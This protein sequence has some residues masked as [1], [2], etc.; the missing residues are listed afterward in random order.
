MY[1]QFGAG[2]QRLTKGLF[3]WFV[4]FGTNVM[5]KQSISGRLRTAVHVL[6]VQIN[7]VLGCVLCQRVSS[8]AEDTMADPCL[9]VCPVINHLL[10]RTRCEMLRRQ[11]TIRS[12]ANFRLKITRAT[13]K[14]RDLGMTSG[15]LAAGLSL[16]TIQPLFESR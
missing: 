12:A 6:A 4:V 1:F 5:I 9:S 2:E 8:P 15:D 13:D 14:N 16:Q 11:S 7:P 10:L 3:I